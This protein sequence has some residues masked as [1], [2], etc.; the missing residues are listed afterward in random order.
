MLLSLN[1][2]EICSSV[3]VVRHVRLVKFLL[4]HTRDLLLRQP[5]VAM[6]V[7]PRSLSLCYLGLFMFTIR[8]FVWV[9]YVYYPEALFLGILYCISGHVLVVNYFFFF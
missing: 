8:L 4:R 9:V 6:L 1:F 7:K 2:Y 3:I 5:C